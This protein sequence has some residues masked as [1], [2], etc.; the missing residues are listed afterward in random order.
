M[1]KAVRFKV[2]CTVCHEVFQNDYVGKHTKSKHK[3]LHTSGRQA[4]VTIELDKSDTCQSK[5]DAFFRSTPAD[6]TKFSG[7]KKRKIPTSV[8]ITTLSEPE[9]GD[10]PTTDHDRESN[11]QKGKFLWISP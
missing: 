2:C 9:E 4:P 1:A 11:T 8:E 10:E 6:D 5:M 3:D 7:A